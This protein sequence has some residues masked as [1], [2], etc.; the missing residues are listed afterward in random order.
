M[1]PNATL[2]P[3]ILDLLEWIARQP[4][5]YADVIEAWRTSCPRLTV[6]EDAVDRGFAVREHSCGRDVLIALTAAGRDFLR[7]RGRM[8]DEAPIVVTQP[9]RARHNA[10]RVP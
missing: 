5:S 4:R 3:L 6:W 2:D 1:T 10:P 7:E 8:T 9:E